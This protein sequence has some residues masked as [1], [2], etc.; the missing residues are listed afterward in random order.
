MKFTLTVSRLGRVADFAGGAPVGINSRNRATGSSLRYGNSRIILRARSP[1]INSDATAA[2]LLSDVCRC[3]ALETAPIYY[4]DGGFEGFDFVFR[5]NSP[6]L[7]A[8]LSTPFD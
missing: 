5:E 4:G 7:L 6:A 1:G 3:G 2:G 8:N